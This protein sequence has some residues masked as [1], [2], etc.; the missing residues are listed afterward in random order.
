MVALVLLAACSSDD[1]D[2]VPSTAPPPRGYVALGDSYSAGEGAR[3]Y[4]VESGSCRRSGKA[5]PA[6]LDRLEERFELLELRACGGATAEHLLGPWESRDQPAQIP[7]DEHPEVGLVTLTVGGNDAGFGEIVLRCVLL[8]CAGVPGSGDYTRG[9]AELTTTLATEVYP[10]LAAAYPR[11]RL[12]HVGYPRLTPAAGEPVVDCSWLSGD[13]RSAAADIV[14]G[15]N[16]A[17]AEAT[18]R[19]SDAGIDVAYLDVTEAFEGHE[20]CSDGVP[21]VNEV[22][23]LDAERAH[24]TVEGHRALAAAVADG[25]DRLR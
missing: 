23:S 18:E 21:W 16:D 6:A 15:L 25:L 9:L 22:L 5:W 10:R 3:E 1:D 17:V 20:L 13:E 8:S 24:P 12:V 4:D 11:A 7:S 14:T 19:A 2:A